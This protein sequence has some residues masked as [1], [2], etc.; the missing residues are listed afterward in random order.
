MEWLFL[1][2]LENVYND[3]SDN[4][5]PYPKYLAYVTSIYL[6]FKNEGLNITQ[7]VLELER[8]KFKN[9]VHSG[10]D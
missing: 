7:I 5:S 1:S 10:F 2:L 6:P 8:K 3:V 4:H 9:F